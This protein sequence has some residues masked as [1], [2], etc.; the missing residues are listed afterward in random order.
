MLLLPAFFAVAH[1]ANLQVVGELVHESSLTSGQS[2]EGRVVLRNDGASAVEVVVYPRDA[3]EEGEGATA[4]AGSNRPWLR[5]TPRLV[6]IGA[7]GTAEV[8]YRIEVPPNTD[9]AGTFGTLLV[10]EPTNVPVWP[11]PADPAPETEAVVG[12][13]VNIVTHVNQ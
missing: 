12:Y 5:F 6:T 8:P 9:V 4:L 11:P 7:G 3:A 2:A 1:A 13:R 10:I